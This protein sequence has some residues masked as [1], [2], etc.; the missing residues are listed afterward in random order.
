MLRF[1]IFLFG[2]SSCLIF[3]N[4]DVNQKTFHTNKIFCTYLSEIN[5]GGSNKIEIYKGFQNDIKDPEKFIRKYGNQNIDFESFIKSAWL[6]SLSFTNLCDN[7]T[8][9]NI[10]K[11]DFDYKNFNSDVKVI[12]VSE[13]YFFKYNK[14][15]FV[16]SNVCGE[17]CEVADIYFFEMDEN[18]NFS[19]KFL[20]FY[21]IS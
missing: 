16:V 4:S 2:L 17:S 6:D 13:F 18:G 14:G 8:K 1:S 15:Y 7:S 9:C 19:V 21:F 10:S 3:K 11:N 5:I 12:R 20:S